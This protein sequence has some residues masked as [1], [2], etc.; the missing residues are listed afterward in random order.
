VSH[1]A[2]LFP[3]VVAAEGLLAVVLLLSALALGT[4]SDATAAPLLSVGL[5]LVASLAIIEPATTAGAGLRAEG[6]QKWDNLH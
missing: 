5:I 2:R 6:E 4:E 1:R 3:W